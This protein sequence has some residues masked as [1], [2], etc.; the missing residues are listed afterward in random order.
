[1][2]K[3]LTLAVLA[4]SILAVGCTKE[5]ENKVASLD[6]RV[7]KLETDVALAIA[8]L[9]D[10]IAKGY[11]VTD[12]Q[13]LADNS[14][15]T[16]TFS[17][18]KTITVVNGKDGAD[19]A[20]GQDGKD[21]K[22]GKDGDAFFESVEI[23]ATT[24]TFKLSTGSQF[25]VPLEAAFSLNIETGKHYVFQDTPFVL[26]YTVTNATQNTTVDCLVS[27]NFVGEVNAED[28]SKGTL[29][30]TVAENADKGKALVYADNGFGKVSVKTV[31]FENGTTKIIDADDFVSGNGGE[32]RCVAISNA[33]YTVETSENW[34]K[35]V[36]TKAVQMD[37]LV[38]T[39]E[40]N[41]G[42]EVRQAEIRLLVGGVVAFTQTVVQE[43]RHGIRNLEDF[44][45]FVQASNTYDEVK[46][47]DYSKYENAEGV[48]RIFNDLDFAAWSHYDD[49]EWQPISDEEAAIAATST[50]VG[51][52]GGFGS[53]LDGQNHVIKNINVN[54]SGWTKFSFITLLDGGTVRNLTFDNS[55]KFT[56][57][58]SSAA[59]GSCYGSIVSVCVGGT[60]ENVHYNGTMYVQRK[61]SAG[62]CCIGGL[63][64]AANPYVGDVVIKDCSFG[65]SLEAYGCTG[66]TT[67][68]STRI[69]G[70]LGYGIRCTA[71][72]TYIPQSEDSRIKISGS[73][74]TGKLDLHGIRVGGIIGE[75]AGGVIVEGCSVSTDVTNTF[76]DN[77]CGKTKY[78]VVRM[79]GIL[80]YENGG[81]PVVDVV[82]N[83]NVKGKLADSM[84]GCVGGIVGFTRAIDLS[85][86]AF[87]GT[88]A[89]HYYGDTNPL[90]ETKSI[91]YVRGLAAG[92]LNAN[93]SNPAES[94]KIASVTAKGYVSKTVSEAGVISDETAATATDLVGTASEGVVTT[95]ITLAE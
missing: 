54:M 14:G 84:Q 56:S 13:Q 31:L 93:G 18:G 15:Y 7:T 83:C 77:N 11:Y 30:I 26:E 48:I 67:N 94:I 57:T 5:L 70:L 72:G 87:E 4:L 28:C 62:Y 85:G 88:V 66:N 3:F 45:G 49:G 90:D 19:G 47:F 58:N 69:G 10:V 91:A 44:W 64:G 61:G 29:T 74:V 27:G 86:C 39:V 78:A 52:Y 36:D 82:K 60:L 73:A 46:G 20:D 81:Y 24:V 68:N 65:G 12:F 33:S 51:G 40:E 21:G 25:V 8:T 37:N 34:I 50:N 2:K 16:I 9:E 89:S 23:G 92:N 38:F 1:M 55:C 22:D 41:P 76:Y 6:T 17:N 63:I 53:I 95:G 42:D 59:A 75:A 35:L 32:Y 71:S 80:G 79:G 43:A